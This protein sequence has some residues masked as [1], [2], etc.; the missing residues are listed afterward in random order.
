MDSGVSEQL[1]ELLGQSFLER[2]TLLGKR[3]AEFHMA[4][5]KDTDNPEL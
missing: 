5:A 2:V 1:V 3:T 4:L